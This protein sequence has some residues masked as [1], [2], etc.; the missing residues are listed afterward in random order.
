MRTWLR[1]IGVG[2]L[3]LAI[4]LEFGNFEA[5]VLALMLVMFIRPADPVRAKR[6][7]L[8]LCAMWIVLCAATISVGLAAIDPHTVARKKLILRLYDLNCNA[9][10]GTYRYPRS[11]MWLAEGRLY[12]DWNAVLVCGPLVK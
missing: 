4:A 3:I 8:S 7:R 2:V 9:P 10:F 6:L 11:V 12:G 5:V 1:R